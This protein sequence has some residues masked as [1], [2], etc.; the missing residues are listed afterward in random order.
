MGERTNNEES[1][2]RREGPNSD[3]HP[4]IVPKF[5]SARALSILA[6]IRS[7]CSVVLRVLLNCECAWMMRET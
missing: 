4:A 1:D 7:G 6:T 3:C 5:T 2:T